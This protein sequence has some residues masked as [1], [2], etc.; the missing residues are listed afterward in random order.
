MAMLAELVS[1]PADGVPLDGLLYEPRDRPAVGCV[2]LLHGNGGNF[3]TG[4]PR[5]LPPHLVARGFAC[6]AYNRRGHDILTTH[7][8]RAAHGNAFQTIAE[9][10]ADNRLAA[11]W[12]AERGYAAPVLVGHS[13]GGMLAVRHAAD[14]R[15][16][17]AMVLLSAHR[18]GDFITTASR[19]GLLARDRLPEVVEH[20]RALVA[21][22]RGDAL[23]SLPSWWYAISASSLLDLMA[24]APDIV[25]LAPRIACPTLYVRGAAEPAELYPAE[26]FAERATGPVDVRVV[27]GCDHWYN[28]IEA[29]VAELVGDWVVGHY[30]GGMTGTS[31]CDPCSPPVRSV[32]LPP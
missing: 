5:F 7:N 4:P 13:N 25:E 28:G 22:G 10:V 16:T 31:R 2:Q 24:N 6:L 12:L 3:Y 19:H 1:I 23:I 15:G 29:T 30:A 32:T 9:S 27:E 11:E 20:A 21:D 17:P 14:H 18:G 8:S 26:A